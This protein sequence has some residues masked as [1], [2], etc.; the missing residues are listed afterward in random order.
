MLLSSAC[1][2]NRPWQQSQPG[3][4]A[5]LSSGHHLPPPGALAASGPPG[6]P[7][8]AALTREG[9][10]IS[11]RGGGWRRE[12]RPSCAWGG[13]GERVQ[14]SSE[15]F[16]QGCCPPTPPLSLFYPPRQPEPPVKPPQHRSP[17]R[18]AHKA[19][20][21][22]AGRTGRWESPVQGE[23]LSHHPEGP[24]RWPCTT[25]MPWSRPSPAASP[26]KDWKSRSAYQQSLKAA[27]NPPAG[28]GGLPGCRDH[29]YS[30]ADSCRQQIPAFPC[31]AGA[32]MAA[33]PSPKPHTNPGDA[34]RGKQQQ[35]AGMCIWQT[36][37]PSRSQLQGYSPRVSKAM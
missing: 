13:T 17:L 23:A 15:P 16:S 34:P 5:L 24:L 6:S 1:S 9:R 35:K 22:Q 10:C 21:L 27:Q 32:G 2:R 18:A 20:E 25:E 26:A 28:G 19:P 37:H 33:D 30:S 36:T 14:G 8:R 29:K 12:H 11:R 31:E 7:P 4:A 3:W